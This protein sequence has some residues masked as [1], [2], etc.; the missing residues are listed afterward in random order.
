MMDNPDVAEA[1]INWANAAI[2]PDDCN[3]KVIRKMI[4][5]ENELFNQRRFNFAL[6]QG[7]LWA[8]ASSL[9]QKEDAKANADLVYIIAG[10]GALM[11][12][13]AVFSFRLTSAAVD[14][15]LE[16]LRRETTENENSEI[17]VVQNRNG[18]N[19]A[20]QNRN[21]ENQA[22]QNRRRPCCNCNQVVHDID[23]VGVGAKRVIG[24]DRLQRQTRWIR[25]CCICNDPS[26]VPVVIAVTWVV[27]AVFLWRK[28]SGSDPMQISLYFWND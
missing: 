25:F 28:E 4:M 3:R 2:A 13:T 26:L 17:Q 1:F 5:H 20:G 18:E 24:L 8:S 14:S 16:D 21:G 6:L 10:A 19:Q 22:H 7:L 9:I 15:L 23:D 11:A 27:F 12:F